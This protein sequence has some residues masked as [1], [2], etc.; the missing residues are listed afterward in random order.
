MNQAGRLFDMKHAPFEETAVPA[1]MNDPSAIDARQRLQAV[2]DRL[3]PAG[4]IMD[5][6][7]GNGRHAGRLIHTKKRKKDQ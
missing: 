3:N 1:D 7:D 6:G 4:G 5:E 2:L